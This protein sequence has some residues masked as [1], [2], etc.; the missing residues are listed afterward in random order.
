[1]IWTR[2]INEINLQLLVIR[3]YDIKLILSELPHGSQNAQ[4]AVMIGGVTAIIQTLSDVL[5]IAIEWYSE[6]DSKNAIFWKE[7]CY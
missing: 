7:G 3:R 5:D 1:M 4:A 2:R 6:Q